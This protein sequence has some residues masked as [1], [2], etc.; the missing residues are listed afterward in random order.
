MGIEL[1]VCYLIKKIFLILKKNYKK[2]LKK[3]ITHMLLVLKLL[4]IDK[5]KRY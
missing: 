1:E 5:K 3:F 2:N 4:V